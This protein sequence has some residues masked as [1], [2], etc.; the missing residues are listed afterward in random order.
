MKTK[1]LK[2]VFAETAFPPVLM[3]IKPK[4]LEMIVSG[5]KTAEVRKSAPRRYWYMFDDKLSFTPT[6]LFYETSPVCSVAYAARITSF[7]FVPTRRYDGKFESETRVTK[8]EFAKYSSNLYG[9][10]LW[11]ISDVCKLDKP[12]TLAEL[13]VIRAPQ[14]WR[15]LRNDEE[16]KK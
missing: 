4:W 13:G 2:E 16:V 11:Y 1:T 8:E 10:Y 15:Y 12:V 9:A 3:S 5:A 14:S 7:D 6:V